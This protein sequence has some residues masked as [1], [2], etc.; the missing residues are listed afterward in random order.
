M[1]SALIFAPRVY[2]YNVT[3]SPRTET[4]PPVPRQTSFEQQSKHGV[5]LIFRSGG[6]RRARDGRRCEAMTR[7]L[8]A[9]NPYSRSVEHPTRTYR[10]FCY[11]IHS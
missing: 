9:N 4:P 2:D 5:T 7:A 1:N 11:T 10:P 8:L 6:G 3:Y